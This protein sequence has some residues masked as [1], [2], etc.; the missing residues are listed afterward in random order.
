MIRRMISRSLRR[1]QLWAF[2]RV[3]RN[4]PS[5]LNALGAKRSK[6]GTISTCWSQN[7]QSFRFFQVKSHTLLRMVRSMTPRR[8]DAPHSALVAMDYHACRL[9]DDLPADRPGLPT[10]VHILHINRSKKDVESPQ[11]QKLSL[12]E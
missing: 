7:C 6:R 1:R 2:R 10:A 4:I 8:P 9:V 5:R 12:V 11:G 3:F